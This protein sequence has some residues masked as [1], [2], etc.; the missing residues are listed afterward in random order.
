MVVIAGPDHGQGSESRLG[1]MLRADPPPEALRWAT[2]VVG[3]GAVQEVR[4]LRGGSSAAMHLVAD[5]DGDIHQRVVL[6]RYLRPEQQAEQPS[7][8]LM[9]AN[10]LQH[11]AAAPVPTPTLLDCDP[12]GALAGAPAVLMTE[13]E[14]Q[15]R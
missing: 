9:E 11:V 3:A 15:P 4:A 13:L 7:W 1:R 12:H 2:S 6:R 5:R 10:A 14:G 8:A